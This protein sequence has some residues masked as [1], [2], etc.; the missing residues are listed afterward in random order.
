MQRFN[1][2]KTVGDGKTNKFKEI[3]RLQIKKAKESILKQVEILDLQVLIRSNWMQ[4]SVF[5]VYKA[6]ASYAVSNE[7]MLVMQNKEKSESRK[8][9]PKQKKKEMRTKSI[10]QWFKIIK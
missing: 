4:I 3:N 6:Q 8:M 9:S 5:Q 10:W 1:I 2:Q 7:A